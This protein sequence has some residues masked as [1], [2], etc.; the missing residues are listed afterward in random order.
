MRIGLEI[1]LLDEDLVRGSL[2]F[3]AAIVE[4]SNTRTKF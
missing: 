2:V 1:L 3:M 4:I